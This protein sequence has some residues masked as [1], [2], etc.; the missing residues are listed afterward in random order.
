MA[1]YAYLDRDVIMIQM[2]T[3]WFQAIGLVSEDPHAACLLA[4]LEAWKR[5]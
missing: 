5:D 4:K 3:T 2:S 1:T